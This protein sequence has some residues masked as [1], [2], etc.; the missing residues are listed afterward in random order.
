MTI[1]KIARM[2]QPVLRR[3]ALPVFDLEDPELSRLIADMSETMREAP[4]VG[5]AAPQIFAGRRVIVYRVPG[6]RGGGGE[7]IPETALINPE[8]E[9]LDDHLSL[10]W[11]GCLSLPGLRGLVPRYKRIAYRGLRPDGT[12]VEGDATGF[13]ARVI[14]HEVDHLDG[15]LYIDRMHDT[16]L[17]CFD[18]EAA[19][20]RYQ[21]YC[22]SD[23]DS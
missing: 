21:D 22:D 20:F 3:E 7:A 4:G 18:S 16:R 12:P 6:D 17:L 1:Q 14:Q 9:P 5:L 10:G 11:E 23:D 19:D 13:L 8:I 2:G 15:I